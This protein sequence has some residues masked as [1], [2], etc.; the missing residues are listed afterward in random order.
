MSDPIEW[1]LRRLLNFK[2]V[3]R[4]RYL[5]VQLGWLAWRGLGIGGAASAA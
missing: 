1:E 3:S 2:R 4:L 5:Q